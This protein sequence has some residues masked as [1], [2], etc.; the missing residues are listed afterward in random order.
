MITILPV[1]AIVAAAAICFLAL[2]FRFMREWNSFG[3]P[4]KA[5][6]E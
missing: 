4:S 1:A 3:M 6:D 2:F 5:P